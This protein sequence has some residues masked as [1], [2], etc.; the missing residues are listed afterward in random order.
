MWNEHTFH[1][2]NRCRDHITSPEI[3]KMQLNLIQNIFSRKNLTLFTQRP[4]SHVNISSPQGCGVAQW[5]R[6]TFSSAPSTQ[7]GSPSQIL[8]KGIINQ[9]L[10]QFQGPWSKAKKTFGRYPENWTFTISLEYIA[11]VPT[12]CFHHMWILF[13]HR[14]Y[15]CLKYERFWFKYRIKNKM[16]FLHKGKK[17]T[18]CIDVCRLHHCCP[19][20]LTIKKKSVNISIIKI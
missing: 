3:S 18:H 15:D 11:I 1:H 8:Q 4:F 16:M 20:N 6:V 12:I 14:T 2:H 13:L 17:N 9:T 19:S 10:V 5:W 7:S